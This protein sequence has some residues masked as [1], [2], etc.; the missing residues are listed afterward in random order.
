MSPEV[1]AALWAVGGSLATLIATNIFNA[2]QADKQIE[3]QIQER[4]IQ[5]KQMLIHNSYEHRVEAYTKLFQSL[6]EFKETL[7]SN[8][9]SPLESSEE[10]AELFRKEALWLSKDANR[11]FKELFVLCNTGDVRGDFSFKIGKIKGIMKEDLGISYIDEF[12]DRKQDD[13]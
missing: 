13:K 10:L 12:K 2:R 7:D 11:A 8:Q 3:F 1:A 9:F 4:E 6:N 5:N